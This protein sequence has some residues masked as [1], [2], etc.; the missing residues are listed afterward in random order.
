[1]REL[2]SANV[3]AVKIAYDDMSWAT[4]QP[5]PMLRGTDTGFPDVV[6]GISSVMEPVLHV[7]AG[8]PPRAALQAATINAARMVNHGG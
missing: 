3:D 5:I 8:L 7:D 1:M 6:S 4:K 2:K